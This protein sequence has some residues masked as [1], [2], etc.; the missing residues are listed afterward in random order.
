MDWKYLYTS[1][2]GR[3]PRSSFWIGILV[4]LGISIVLSVVDGIAG[5]Q[6]GQGVGILSTIFAIICIYPA[7]ALYAKRWHDR[8][9]SGWW[10]LIGFVP[11]IGAIWIIVELGC[12]RGTVGQNTYGA[13]PLGG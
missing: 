1:F 11:I 6:F 13:D 5:L 9:K 3:I 7:V 2:E 10:T 4:I 8:N 12:L